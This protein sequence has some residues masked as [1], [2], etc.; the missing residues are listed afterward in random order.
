MRR[1]IALFP[2][3]D[4]VESR[5]FGV[6]DG[7][8]QAVEAGETSER[9]AKAVKASPEWE[10]YHKHQSVPEAS[11]EAVAPIEPPAYLKE[12]IRRRVAASQARFSPKPKAGQIVE[13]IKIVTPEPG[14]LDWEMQVPLYVLLDQ[15]A[16]TADLW[17]GWLVSAETDYATSW[18]FVLQEQDAPFDPE[19]GMV[20]IWNPGLLYLPMAGRVVA[21]LRAE[22]LEAVR[23]LA[24]DF[25]LSAEPTETPWPGRV[26]VRTTSSGHEVVTGS[27]KGGKD[28]PRHRYQNMYHHAAEA[29]REP[30]N[31]VRAKAGLFGSDVADPNEEAI[32]VTHD[33]AEA[34]NALRSLRAIV[35]TLARRGPAANDQGYRLAARTEDRASA[36]ATQW[37]G[38]GKYGRDEIQIIAEP[39]DGTDT[40]KVAV[41]VLIESPQTLSAGIALTLR[42]A[43]IE[44]ERGTRD[45]ILKP[46]GRSLSRLQARVLFG[47]PWK[48]L[49]EALAKGDG[50]AVSVSN[51]R[52]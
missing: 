47:I 4:R 24:T 10:D 37:A 9:I 5:L 16:E 46:V 2:S 21:E 14:Q 1:R 17:Q 39:T 36:A 35:V 26:A 20:Q 29:I 32:S 33:G 40:A 19:A 13:V 11:G 52:L 3:L 49:A 45:V 48:E 41:T 22:R 18:D 27:P 43:T 50:I 31:F 23:A 15:P 6:S 38:T 51:P 30:A 28:D 7:L 44:G 12:L 25:L 42:L 34:L 8:I